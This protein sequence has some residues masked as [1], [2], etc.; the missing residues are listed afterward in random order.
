MAFDPKLC[1]EKHRGI[2][3]SM[4]RL[5]GFISLFALLIVSGIVTA[6]VTGSN[7]AAKAEVVEA[8]LQTYEHEQ[9]QQ[10]RQIITLLS[11]I[12]KKLEKLK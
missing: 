12:S 11:D 6:Y 8:R 5:W 3:A 10:Q 7:A 2:S 9:E 1:E 4:K